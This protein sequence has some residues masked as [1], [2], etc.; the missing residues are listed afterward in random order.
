MMAIN[1]C[2]AE[3]KIGKIEDWL[4]LVGFIYLF[5]Y[6]FWLVGWIGFSFV[7]SFEFCCKSFLINTVLHSNLYFCI[8]RSDFQLQPFLHYLCVRMWRSCLLND[9]QVKSLASKLHDELFCRNIF[10][11]DCANFSDVTASGNYSYLRFFKKWG[12]ELELINGTLQEFESIRE[13]QVPVLTG[14]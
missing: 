14:T 10:L 3:G 2:N 4:F 13:C 12:F 7:Y 6:L 9:G 1:I 5:V 8:N 11:I